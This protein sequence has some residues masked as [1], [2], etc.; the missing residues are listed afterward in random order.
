MF[1]PRASLSRFGP[2]KALR[3]RDFAVLLGG[4]TLVGFV[5][6]MQ[7]LTQIF[8]IQDEYPG[9]DVLYVALLAGVRGSAMLT[10]SLL[11]GAI[12]DRFERR[13]VLLACEIW[14]CP[15]TPLLPC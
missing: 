7:F 4:T 12:A 13:R 8:W 6:P 9:R 11:G 10:F 1:S 2:L 3:H 15:S 5:M 14:P